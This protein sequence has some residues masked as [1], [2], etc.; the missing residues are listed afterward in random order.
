MRQHH[1]WGEWRSAE[2]QKDLKY[3]H[4]RWPEEKKYILQELD[5]IKESDVRYFA[6]M[7]NMLDWVTYIWI[8]TGIVARVFALTGDARAS[9]HHKK[10]LAT[11]L[12]V[13]WLRLM[14][15]IRA[16]QA[17]GEF[18]FVDLSVEIKIS[19]GVFGYVARSNSSTIKYTSAKISKCLIRKWNNT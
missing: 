14:K 4:P 12:I 18:C 1:K 11:S 8:V 17:L 2:I 7:W 5:R 6:D 13:I 3:C 10:I 15:I 9:G 16:Y 19:I